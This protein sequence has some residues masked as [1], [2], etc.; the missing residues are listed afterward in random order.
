VRKYVRIAVL[1]VLVAGLSGCGGNQNTLDPASHAESSID[2]VFWVMLAASCVGFGVIAVLLFVAWLRRNRVVTEEAAN[3]RRLTTL[4]VVLGVA[5]PIVLLSALF[6]WADVFVVD[7][8]AAP[9]PGKAQ[10]TIHVIAHQWWWEIRYPGTKAVTANEIHV[11]TNTRVDLVGTTADVIHDLWIP[12]LNRKVDLIPGMT[13][14]ILVDADRPGRFRGQCAEFCGVQHTH[15]AIAVIAESPARFRAW[16]ANMEKPAPPPVT[17]MQ[18]A[19]LAVF[20]SEPCAS[21]HTIRGTAARGTVGPDL[22]HLATRSELA[23]ETIPNTPPYLRGWIAD[24]QAVK[25]GAKMPDLP[26]TTKEVDELAAYLG[27]LH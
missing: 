13:N 22:T 18:K 9:P 21:C 12:E 7:S 27:H 11:P 3:E 16:L 10:L 19:G 6:I 15:M 26:L 23:A 2:R 1:G 24:P 14:T 5:V 8:T 4:V 17:P 20:L 25:P